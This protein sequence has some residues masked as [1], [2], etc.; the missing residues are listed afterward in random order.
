ML[1]T[2]AE[3]HSFLDV[4]MLIAI[5][6][7]NLPHKNF[8]VWWLMTLTWNNYTEQ[9]I[10]R[11]NSA[12][13]GVRALNAMLS[14]TVLRMLYISYIHSVTYGI[15]FGGNTTNSIKIFRTQ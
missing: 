12:C 10:S 15:I 3:K 1:K 8:W 4:I 2:V 9:F 11:L 14:K 6:I 5:A 13:Y 7:A